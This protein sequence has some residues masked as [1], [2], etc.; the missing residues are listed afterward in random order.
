MGDIFGYLFYSFTPSIDCNYSDDLWRTAKE[1]CH[2]DTNC[3][4][5]NDTSNMECFRMS[6]YCNGIVFCDSS[7]II[8]PPKEVPGDDATEIGA[9]SCDDWITYITVSIILLSLMCCITPCF[10][11]LYK[12]YK[13]SNNDIT[14]VLNFKLKNISITINKRI[15]IISVVCSIILLFTPIVMTLT[16]ENYDIWH[17]IWMWEI[18][19]QFV[20]M[21]PILAIVYFSVASINIIQKAGKLSVHS[22]CLV[23]IYIL[24]WVILFVFIAMIIYSIIKHD[25]IVEAMAYVSLS[26]LLIDLWHPINQIQTTPSNQLISQ[27]FGPNVCGGFCN[28]MVQKCCPKT[29]E[30][31]AILNGSIDIHNNEEMGINIDNEEFEQK[32]N[33]D[34]HSVVKEC[35]LKYWEFVCYTTWICSFVALSLIYV[36]Y[37][38]CLLSLATFLPT[39]VNVIMFVKH[40]K[41]ELETRKISIGCFYCIVTFSIIIFVSLISFTVLSCT[42]ID[43]EGGSDDNQCE[44]QHIAVIAVVV[45]FVFAHLHQK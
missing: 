43:D 12:I 18:L 25:E 4:W 2:W 32:Y 29:Y 38:P 27:Y 21:I 33:E 31:Y 35:S 34:Q 36:Q 37:Q 30:E 1:W 40:E 17:S 8:W 20:I 22:V 15:V 11:L 41:F 14:Q 44:W 16:F 39:F 13:S 19:I 5:C 3:L 9:Q 45:V 42:C 7:N 23:F 26:I 10:C 24:W 28:K 6:D